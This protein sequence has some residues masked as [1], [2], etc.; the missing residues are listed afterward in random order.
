VWGR[1]REYF[2]GKQSKDFFDSLLD[3]QLILFLGTQLPENDEF[4]NRISAL[5][6]GETLSESDLQRDLDTILLKYDPQKPITTNTNTS[7]K[8]NPPNNTINIPKPNITP[9]NLNNQNDKKKQDM[10]KE[11]MGMGF[12]NQQAEEAIFATNGE[13]LESAVNFLISQVNNF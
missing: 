12:T 11:I 4:I 1:V 6:K 10:I 13:N 9:P 3:F 2:R 8:I 7:P 5:Y